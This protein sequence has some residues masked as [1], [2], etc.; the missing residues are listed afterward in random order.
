MEFHTRERLLYHV[1]KQEKC[2]NFYL[3]FQSPLS[4]D[5]SRL[6]DQQAASEQLANRK[7]GIQPR[8]AHRSA[9]RTPGPQPMG[10]A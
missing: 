5:E 8:A 7:A 9:Y 1:K 6:L 10:A 3:R 4:A 2:K